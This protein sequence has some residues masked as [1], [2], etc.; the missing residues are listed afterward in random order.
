MEES[1]AEGVAIAEFPTTDRGR[2][3]SHAAGMAVLMGAPNIVRG[4]SHSGNVAAE[5]LARGGMLDILSS[6]YVPA[7][8]LQAAFMLPDRVPAISLARALA[9]VTAAPPRAVGLDDRGT[10]EVGRRADLV[11]VHLADGMPV[12][13]SVWREGETGRLTGDGT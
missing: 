4:G 2:R 8:L 12:V 9:T 7:S 3:A 10:L 13:R 11:H 1:I 5:E 6:D